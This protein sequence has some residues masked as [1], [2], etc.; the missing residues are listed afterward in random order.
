MAGKFFWQSVERFLTFEQ[1]WSPGSR[2]KI[3]FDWVRNFLDKSLDEETK[4]VYR[5][6]SSS[7]FALF[8]NMV[9]S[10]GPREVVED[11]E[12]FM[13]K[14]GIYAMDPAIG[15]CGPER[16]YTVPVNGINILFTKAHM[17]PPQGA[18]ARNYGRL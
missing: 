6:E 13:E 9:R 12:K 1:G 2:S 15:R 5:T 10:F 3:Q 17:A 14:E 8:W 18:L 11:F 16:Q 7:A 4:D